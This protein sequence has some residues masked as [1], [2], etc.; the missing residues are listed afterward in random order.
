MIDFYICIVCDQSWTSWL[1]D[2]LMK[3]TSSFINIYSSKKKT[4]KNNM[5]ICVRANYSKKKVNL[6]FF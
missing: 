3:N 6:L 2:C 5:Y 4:W 1:V